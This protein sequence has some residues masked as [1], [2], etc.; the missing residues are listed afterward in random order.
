[1]LECVPV[2]FDEYLQK[3]DPDYVVVSIE[4]NNQYLADTVRSQHRKLVFY[5]VNTD[6]EITLALRASPYGIVTNFPDRFI[7]RENTIA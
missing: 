5:T 1:M 4:T 6:P 3:V 2:F 7:K